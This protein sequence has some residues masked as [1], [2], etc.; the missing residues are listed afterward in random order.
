M[1]LLVF[2]LQFVNVSFLNVYL[3]S[4]CH[5]S[6]F[7]EFS[8]FIYCDIFLFSFVILCLFLLQEILANGNGRMPSSGFLEPI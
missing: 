7:G 1:I 6:Y 3:I 5:C 2:I 4:V 8:S